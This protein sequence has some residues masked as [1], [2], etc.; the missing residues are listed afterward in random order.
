VTVNLHWKSSEDD[1]RAGRMRCLMRIR[2]TYGH[3]YPE[4]SRM[5]TFVKMFMG[6]L[7]FVI[8]AFWVVMMIPWGGW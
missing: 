3:N 6:A 1:E 7:V 4:K 2:R 8:L 5:K